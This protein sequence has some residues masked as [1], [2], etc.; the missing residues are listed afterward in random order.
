MITYDQVATAIIVVVA[1]CAA[2]AVIWNAIKAVR[3]M[4]KPY[5][6]LSAMVEEHERKLANDHKRLDDLKTS[7]DLQAKMLLQ[8]A[9]HMIDGNHNDQLRQ[10]RDE[11]QEYLIMR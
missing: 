2:L 3:E 1:V 5:D 10:A 4:K 9:N 11:L 6:D 7:N 8:M